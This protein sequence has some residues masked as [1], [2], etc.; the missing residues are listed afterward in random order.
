MKYYAKSE[1]VLQEFG[2][3]PSFNGIQTDCQSIVT[4]L[5]NSLKDQFSQ[6]EVS[7]LIPRK[8]DRC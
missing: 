7:F 6:A 4:E 5:K 3:H 1:Q 8:E 2:T